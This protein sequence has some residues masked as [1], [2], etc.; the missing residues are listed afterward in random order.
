[1]TQQPSQNKQ[2]IAKLDEIVSELAKV[3]SD[4]EVIKERAKMQPQIDQEQ[5][6]KQDEK[7]A[8][9]ERRIKALEDNQRWIIIAVFGAVINAIMQLILH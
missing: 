4:I 2:I 6:L 5:R 1:M 7:I 9:N 3:K 8:Q